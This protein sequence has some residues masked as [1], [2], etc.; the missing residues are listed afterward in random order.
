LNLEEVA[1]RAKVSTATVSRVVNETG[2]VKPSTRAR[3]L[4]VIAELN[5]HPNLHA[6]TLAGGK[7]RTIGMIVSNLENPFFLD[8]FSIVESLAHTRGYDVVVANTDYNSDQLVRSVRLMIGRR[9]AG[10]AVIVSEMEPVL[11]E[12]LTSSPTP[13]VFYDVGTARKNITNIRVNYR[14]GIEKAVSYLH[15]LGHRR[16]GFVGHHSSLGPI[17]ERVQSVLTM[18]A[19]FKPQIE[20]VQA[21]DSDALEG[22][23]RA[24]RELL[25]SSLKPTAIMCVND[26]MAVG[27]LRELRQQGLR[28]PQDVSVTGCDNIRLS[29]YVDPPLTTIHIPRDIVGQM[30]F[31]SL[32]PSGERNT[33][34]GRELVIEPEFLVRE[35]TAPAPR[36]RESR[37]G[38]LVDA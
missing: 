1:K 13:V 17:N 3:V 32:L 26:F 23:R 27:V 24:A 37:V 6:R 20:V 29:E 36:P 31:E 19:R 9:V 18:V 34:T 22:G 30:V 15:D 38:A 16:I 33:R 21:T 28:V 14:T 7:S 11:I 5:Y 10:L 25:S 35:S 4:K 8:I 12:L 2:L